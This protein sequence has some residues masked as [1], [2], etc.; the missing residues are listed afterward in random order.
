[1]VTGHIN[2]NFEIDQKIQSIIARESCTYILAKIQP[3]VDELGNMRLPRFPYDM[4][5]AKIWSNDVGNMVELCKDKRST[6]IMFEC[7]ENGQAS[8]GGFV[9]MYVLAAGTLEN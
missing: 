8:N 9:N 6:I 1:M 5:T 4:D 2:K 7:W 3:L